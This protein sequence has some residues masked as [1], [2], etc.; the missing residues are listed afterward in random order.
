MWNKK[1]EEEIIYKISISSYIYLYFIKL[2]SSS[3]KK[4]KC[5]PLFYFILNKKNIKFKG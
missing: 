5:N 4:S 3:F 2:F 1:K